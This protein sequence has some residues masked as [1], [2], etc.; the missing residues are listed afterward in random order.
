MNRRGALCPGWSVSPLPTAGQPG[1]ARRG[2]YGAWQQR[3][4][5]VGGLAVVP[6]GHRQFQAAAVRVLGY[7]VENDGLP[8]GVVEY[9]AG[10]RL[11]IVGGI[12]ISGGAGHSPQVHGVAV[13][14]ELQ[15]GGVLVVRDNERD[16]EGQGPPGAPAPRRRLWLRRRPGTGSR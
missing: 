3:R 11:G 1:K 4:G 7:G 14:P 9:R 15:Y 16:G 5:K 10:G 8:L 13:F 2:K 12:V 6:D